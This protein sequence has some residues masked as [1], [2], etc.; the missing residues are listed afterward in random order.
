M[1]KRPGQGGSVTLTTALTNWAHFAKCGHDFRH[2]DLGAHLKHSDI[3]LANGRAVSWICA[4]SR[5]C[6]YPDVVVAPA[7]ALMV[8]LPHASIHSD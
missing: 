2:V 6:A 1:E 3:W 7:N 4:L 8:G 5:F